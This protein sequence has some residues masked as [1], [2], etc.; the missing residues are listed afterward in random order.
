MEQVFTSKRAVLWLAGVVVL[1]VGVV[2]AA[3]VLPATSKTPGEGQPNIQVPRMK[4]VPPAEAPR[5]RLD[6]DESK[7]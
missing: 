7:R 1:V 2:V 6:T 5:M 4:N 3:V